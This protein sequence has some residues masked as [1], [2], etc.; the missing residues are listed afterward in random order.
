M[1]VDVSVLGK[2]IT[3]RNGMKA[4]NVFLK[5]SSFVPGKACR[6]SLIILP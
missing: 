1:T 4:P 6:R 3:F 5:V 2:P